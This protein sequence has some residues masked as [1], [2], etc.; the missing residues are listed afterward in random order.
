MITRTLLLSLAALALLPA[1]AIAGDISGD[2]GHPTV[3]A[4][5]ND[6]TGDVQD[7]NQ[8]GENDGAEQPSPTRRTAEDGRYPINR[9]NNDGHHGDFGND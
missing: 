1:A 7:T 5:N 6:D 8:N 3:G 2:Y 4:D 9:D